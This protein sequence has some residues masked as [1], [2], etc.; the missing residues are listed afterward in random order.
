LVFAIE[1]DKSLLDYCKVIIVTATELPI[2]NSNKQIVEQTVAKAL[3]PYRVADGFHFLQNH[4]LIF[5]GKKL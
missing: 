3:Q 1:Q 2:N 4:F 5:I